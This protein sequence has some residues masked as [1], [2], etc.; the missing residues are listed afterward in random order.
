MTCAEEYYLVFV[1]MRAWAIW[2][3]RK[4]VTQVLIMG[5]ICWVLML[6]GGATYGINKNGSYSA[7]FFSFLSFT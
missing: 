1:L 6:M 2:G 4:R 3:T 7:A 5:Y